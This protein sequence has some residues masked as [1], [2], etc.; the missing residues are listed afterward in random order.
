MSPWLRY[1]IGFVVACHG[2]VYVL[3]LFVPEV[4][5]GWRGRSWLARDALTGERLKTLLT[6][7]HVGAGIL[8]LASGAAI[9]LAAWLP[10]WWR[11]LAILGSVVGI[12]AF[13]LFWDG[14]TR[15]VV[16]EGGIG[17]ALS[18]LVLVIAI[19]LPGAFG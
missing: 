19:A 5:E 18:L 16:E 11:P 13:A 1:L 3:L 14:Q 4:F 17:A 12:V 6:A 7:L 8:L 9:G 2:F 15:R 10:G